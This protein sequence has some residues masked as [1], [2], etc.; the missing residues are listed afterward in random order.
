MERGWSCGKGERAS[1][2]VP[3]LHLLQMKG[4]GIIIQDSYFKA[5]FQLCEGNFSVMLLG[6]LGDRAA[7]TA[8]ATPGAWASEAQRCP[9]GSSSGCVG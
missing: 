4:L 7:V 9:P 3:T 8:P 5:A 6:E 1:I 2:S